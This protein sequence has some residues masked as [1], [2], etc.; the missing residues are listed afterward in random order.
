MFAQAFGKASWA[1]AQ[2]PRDASWREA[3]L[4]YFQ[5]LRIESAMGSS[6]PT[7]KQIA[8]LQSLGCTMVH[9]SSPCIPVD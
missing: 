3:D 5:K 7:P 1:P 8:Y 6:A 2:P 9:I 4:E